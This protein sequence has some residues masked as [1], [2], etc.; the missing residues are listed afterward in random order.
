MLLRQL[1]RLVGQFIQRDGAAAEKPFQQIPAGVERDPDEPGLLVLGAFKHSGAEDIFQKHG[2]K[3]ILR[4]G[5]I[6]QMH[7]AEP[8]YQ[9]GIAVD[10]AVGLLFAA[11]V[12]TLLLR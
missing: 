7:H 9:I 4:V 8:P 10:G 1:V 3:D 12:L 2:L 6:F 5:R 11:H